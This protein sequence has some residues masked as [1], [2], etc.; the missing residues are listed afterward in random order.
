ML[1]QPLHRER[2]QNKFQRSGMRLKLPL[3]ANRVSV[4]YAERAA[5]RKFNASIEFCLAL[6]E[7]TRPV[8]IGIATRTAR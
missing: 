4:R 1:R 7:S 6:A 3:A 5:V 2:A 8:M